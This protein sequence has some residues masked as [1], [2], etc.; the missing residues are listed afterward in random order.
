MILEIL[1]CDDINGDPL[2]EVWLWCATEKFGP[3]AGGIM[4][5]L[6]TKGWTRT[7]GFI[8]TRTDS[9]EQTEW[10]TA[11]MTPAGIEAIR[12]NDEKAFQASNANG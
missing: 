3:A 11:R 10:G 12:A 6:V 8:G 5:S 2:G 7:T 1:N 4:A 9:Y